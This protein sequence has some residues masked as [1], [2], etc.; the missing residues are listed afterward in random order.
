LPVAV[1]AGFRLMATERLGLVVIAA[2]FLVKTQV[3][4]VA[5]KP[6]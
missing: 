5:Q 3:V 6:P 2:R 4:V 1:A